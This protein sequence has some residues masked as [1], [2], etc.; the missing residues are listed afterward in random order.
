MQLSNGAT[1]CRR[2]A[3]RHRVPSFRRSNDVDFASFARRNGR[4]TVS[5]TAAR[6]SFVYSRQASELDQF[7][8]T[9]G[10]P[11]SADEDRS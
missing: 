10:F 4:S 6:T 7:R 3:S 5:S 9:K 2:Q 8:G 11:E 1:V